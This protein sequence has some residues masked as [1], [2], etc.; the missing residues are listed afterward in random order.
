MNP[1]PAA[2]GICVK[3]WMMYT[4]IQKTPAVWN[5]FLQLGNHHSVFCNAAM[6]VISEDAEL[7]DIL[8]NRLVCDRSHKF[9]EIL[10]SKF[11]NCMAGNYAKRLSER[12]S[13]SESSKIRKLKSQ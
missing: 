13:A 7:E 10:V 1:S 11:F 9:A 5:E 4:A 2:F 8:V 6:E 3:C 12:Q